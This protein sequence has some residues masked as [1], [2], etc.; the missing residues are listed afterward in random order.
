MSHK[1]DDKGRG[2]LAETD[3]TMLDRAFDRWLNNQLHRLYDPVLAETVP[4]EMMRLLEQFET[5]TGPPSES[6]SED[7]G[8]S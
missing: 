6:S 2:N 5:R 3:E 4:E 8:K 7:E 1:D